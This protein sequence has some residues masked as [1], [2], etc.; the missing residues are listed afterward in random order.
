MANSGRFSASITQP[1][2]QPKTE[3]RMIAVPETPPGAIPAGARKT[4]SETT[5]SK[6]P[7]VISSAD[8]S[9]TLQFRVSPGVTDAAPPMRLCQSYDSA[10]RWAGAIRSALLERPGGS[11]LGHHPYRMGWKRDRLPF[12]HL[13]QTQ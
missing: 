7:P 10:G 5:I 9:Q 8:C 12:T 13:G 3:F 2:G 6:V 4:V 11:T 1:I